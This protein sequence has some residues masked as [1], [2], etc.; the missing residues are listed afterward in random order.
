MRTDGRILTRQRIR[1]CFFSEWAWNPPC[2]RFS[3]S[4]LKSRVR[5]GQLR[6]DR[7]CS[8]CFWVS[9]SQE[10]GTDRKGAF[11]KGACLV[12]VPLLL[13]EECQIVQRLR[14][15]RIILTEMLFSDTQRTLIA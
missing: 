12:Q 1:R 13:L 5:V 14:R 15:L 2:T 11:G 3:R 9:I 4:F 10:L 6:I 8:H 7:S